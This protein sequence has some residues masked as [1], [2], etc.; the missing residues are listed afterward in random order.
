MQARCLM[1]RLFERL[2]LAISLPHAG[3]EVPGPL[4]KLCRLGADRISA[5]ADLE[6]GAI[7]RPLADIVEVF[8]TTKVA[9]VIV[10]PNRAEDD[11]RRDGV[12]KTHASGED[13]VFRRPLAETE[14][15]GLIWR[16]H[17]P[18]HAALARSA[19]RQRFGL[20][21]HTRPAAAAPQGAG[22]P[23]PR[24]R[25]WLGNAGGRSC[26][27]ETLDGL[28]QCLGKYLGGPVAI[29][30]HDDDGYITWSRPGGIPWVELAVSQ[31]QWM[32]LTDKR[33]AVRAALI[34]F[35][36]QSKLL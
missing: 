19:A 24:P 13:A 11:R 3:R 9:R 1:D 14:I 27:Q 32:S 28:T 2:P 30:R 25:A 7:F 6:S 21:C 26:S 20:D 22:K 31:G 36:K 23:A 17:R 4:A 15:E 33:A 8:V 12:V 16:Y 29:N 35:C 10:D 18:Y 34:E 5:A